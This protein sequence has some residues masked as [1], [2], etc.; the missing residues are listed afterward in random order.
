MFIARFLALFVATL[1]TAGPVPAVHQD[2]FESESRSPESIFELSDDQVHT[3]LPD[4]HSPLVTYLRMLGL[5]LVMVYYD[6]A[7]WLS[8]QRDSILTSLKAL[9]GN[10]P[11]QHAELSESPSPA[12]PV[13]E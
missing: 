10:A 5:K 1:L 7:S 11:T 12:G 6:F 9:F 2:L 8:V 3:K 4:L 13:D